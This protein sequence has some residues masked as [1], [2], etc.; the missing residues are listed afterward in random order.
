MIQKWMCCL[1]MTLIF[2]GCLGLNL[3]SL[4]ASSASVSSAAADTS[5]C[6]PLFHP[7][8]ARAERFNVFQ[9]TV[10]GCPPDFQ[11][12]AFTGATQA[13]N[14]SVSYEVPE[15]KAR[16]SFYTLPTRVG[17][18][19]LMA[20]SSFPQGL[21]SRQLSPGKTV[22]FLNKCGNQTVLPAA[23]IA[24]IPSAHFVPFTAQDACSPA[25]RVPGWRSDYWDIKV[26]LEQGLSVVTLHE[27]TLAPD[28]PQAFFAW[29][30]RQSLP[31][32]SV[33]RDTLALPGVI[34]TWASGL[35]LAVHFLK[36]HPDF[37]Q[38]KIG[39]LGH[40]RRG[41]AALLATAICPEVDF[42]VP[43]QT[44]TLGM[45]SVQDH[46]LESLGQITGMFPH[47]F[48]PDLREMA[49]EAL[50]CDQSVLIQQIAPRPV[51]ATEGY[52]DPWASY[53][54][55]L[56][57]LQRAQSVYASVYAERQLPMNPLRTYPLANDSAL[58]KAPLLHV[59]L[60]HPHTMHG[61]YW[62]V[63]GAFLDQQ[64]P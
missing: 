13:A 40:S 29:R 61:D 49:P 46:P 44:G 8:L 11:Y 56:T 22:L 2:L 57:T 59:T 60:L 10:Y 52:L 20:V 24:Q 15:M 28:H 54:L 62:R 7:S 25:M 41:K 12:E 37:R 53:W 48:S 43:H 36:A 51:V 42:V 27:S 35:E 26:A 45:A 9:K 58:L 6:E 30:D 55:S 38:Q 64:W 23:V 34:A 18:L 3:W 19:S 14:P 32:A 63:I 50:C 16:V 47:W 17:K 39:L 4:P 5:A 33:V 1:R 31:A 21:S